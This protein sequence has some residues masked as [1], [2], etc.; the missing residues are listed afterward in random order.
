M[1]A[2]KIHSPEE[3]GLVRGCAEDIFPGGDYIYIRIVIIVMITYR[4]GINAA[5]QEVFST[6]VPFGCDCIVL[7]CMYKAG[8]NA[9]SQE[10]L[11][12]AL[13]AK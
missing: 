12:M 4:A 8:I 13:G 11:S 3:T 9:A 10:A 5:L 2:R 6:C 7:Y 1:D